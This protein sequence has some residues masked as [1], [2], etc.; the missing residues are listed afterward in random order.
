M[1][2]TRLSDETLIQ[3]IARSQENAL[4]ELYDRYSRLVYSVALN[5]LSD[6]VRAEEVTQDVFV[7]V[8]EK[9]RT[10]NA[11][12]GRVV[13]WLA[14][15]ARHRSI[16]LFRQFR[17][18]RENLQV[19]WQEAEMAD[20]PDGQNVEWEVDLAQRQQR[21]RWAVS[22]LPIDQKQALGMAFFQGMTHPEIA[23]VLGEPLG[24]VKTR[25]RLGMQKLR[26]ILQD[27]YLA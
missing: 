20:L 22:Q 17:A 7:R 12:Q 1:D 26:A 4:S 11:E 3:L 9:A 25:I 24:T 6:P 23:Q 2:Y 16:D 19:T 21:I 18:H 8:W 27:D 10:Y 15:I 14:S 13:G 5:T